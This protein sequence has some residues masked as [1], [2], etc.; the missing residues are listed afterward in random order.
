M[1]YLDNRMEPW[2]VLFCSFITLASHRL[3]DVHVKAI[4]G[5]HT[6]DHRSNEDVALAIGTVTS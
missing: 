1:D 4:G 6:D 2:N 3:F 5:I